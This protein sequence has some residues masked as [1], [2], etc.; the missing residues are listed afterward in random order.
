M[1]HSEQLNRLCRLCGMFLGK[2]SYSVSEYIVDLNKAFNQN[3]HND[4]KEIH[5]K[6]FCSKCYMKKRHIV[7]GSGYSHAAQLGIF[8]WTEHSD[9]CRVCQHVSTIQKGGIKRKRPASGRPVDYKIWC[10]RRRTELFQSLP[11]EVLSVNQTLKSI[12]SE[13]TQIVLCKCSLCDDLMKMPVIIKSCLHRFCFECLADSIEG[14]GLYDLKC[15]TCQEVFSYNQIVDD[16]MVRGIKESLAQ[17]NK[18]KFKLIDIL[19]IKKSSEIPT[20]LEKATYH[21][22]KLKMDSS[23]QPSK[24]IQL[25]SGGPKVSD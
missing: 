15:P 5:P 10:K 23:T 25:K 6:R 8:H 14:Q 20:D 7:K 13:N 3:V 1:C 16:N 22:V 12:S 19:N 2:R 17:E 24:K 21:I 4:K 9:D 18:G 11:V